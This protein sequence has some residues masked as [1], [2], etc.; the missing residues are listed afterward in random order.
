MYK[1]MYKYIQAQLILWDPNRNKKRYHYIP[2]RYNRGGLY[3]LR[4]SMDNLADE[5]A[6][7]ECYDIY[8]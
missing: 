5:D 4:E 3:L 1:Y 2:N 6:L 8:P 7:C